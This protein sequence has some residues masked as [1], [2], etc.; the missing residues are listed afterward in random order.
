M[1]LQ[2]LVFIPS[3][4][5]IPNKHLALCYKPVVLNAGEGNVAF[6][7]TFGN[8]ERDFRLSQLGGEVLMASSA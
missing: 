1:A 7:D 6:Q 3:I 2:F 8:A 5:S 4:I